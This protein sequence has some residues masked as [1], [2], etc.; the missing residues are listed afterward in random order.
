MYVGRGD[1]RERLGLSGAQLPWWT[2]P[3]RDGH[4]G[5]LGCM[6]WKIM[7]IDRKSGTTG[8]KWKHINT[9]Q[10]IPTTPFTLH[11]DCNFQIQSGDALVLTYTLSML[12]VACSR[13]TR[14]WLSWSYRNGHHGYN[15]SLL[16]V[17]M[18]PAIHSDPRQ[19]ALSQIT[20]TNL[21]GRRW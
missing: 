3:V 4:L 13:T 9:F 8:P 11:L 6:T 20:S 17:L 15:T 7:T 2:S 21:E 10:E 1:G 19:A 5:K 18:E 16:C 14:F 12:Q